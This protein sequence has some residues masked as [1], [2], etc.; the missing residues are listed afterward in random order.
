MWC[1]YKDISF[2]YTKK[3]IYITTRLS[4]LKGSMVGV[5]DDND[6]LRGDIS[7]SNRSLDPRSR[8]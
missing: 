2:S 3:E 7:N 4:F 1:F 8:N 5:E 6:E